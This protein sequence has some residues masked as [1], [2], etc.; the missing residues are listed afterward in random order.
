MCFGLA[1]MRAGLKVE[2]VRPQ[3]ALLPRL[4]GGHYYWPAAMEYPGQMLRA[5]RAN[6]L[7]Q[8]HLAHAPYQPAAVAVAVNWKS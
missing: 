6:L 4:P 1:A 3:S 5:G 7:V 2:L 8:E